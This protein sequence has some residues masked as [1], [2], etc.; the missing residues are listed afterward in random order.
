MLII[1]HAFVLVFLGG[2]T[3]IEISLP[4]NRILQHV[5][6]LPGFV[7]T[8]LNMLCGPPPSSEPSSAPSL[9]PD[10]VL[11]KDG[12]GTL[13]V[14][15]YETYTGGIGLNVA[16][17][18]DY[19]EDGDGEMTWD[20]LKK[21]TT[22][23]TDPTTYVGNPFEVDT[24]GDELISRAELDVFWINI[25]ANYTE[26]EKDTKIANY[27]GNGDGIITELELSTAIANGI[28]KMAFLNCVTA[29]PTPVPVPQ[30]ALRGSEDSISA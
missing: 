14:E 30:R 7:N 28:H 22:G 3:A 18:G 19:D 9:Y 17:H 13:S 23:D 15:E 5:P 10:F 20:E 16:Q 25:G 1:R 2:A 26:A 29:P 12:S 11:D 8:F 21:G 4:G 27:D 24:N 6:G